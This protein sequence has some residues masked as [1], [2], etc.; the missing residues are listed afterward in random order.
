MKASY[1]ADEIAKALE[2]TKTPQVAE[3]LETIEGRCAMGVIAA[4]LCNLKGEATTDFYGNEIRYFGSGAHIDALP[5]ECV[6]ACGFVDR[7]GTF[8]E[9]LGVR[10]TKDGKRMRMKVGSIVEA[11]D[12]GVP[13]KTIAKLVRQNP[14]AVQWEA[15]PKPK[16]KRK[17]NAPEQ[18]AEMRRALK[19]ARE[20]DP[21]SV[22]IVKHGEVIDAETVQD[23]DP[24]LDAFVTGS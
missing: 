24:H 3:F 7:L 13:F 19:R 17:L 11:N 21:L 9:P 6:K 12:E 4:E 8:R 15:P 20:A 18:T 14:D 2:S 16:R 23:S 1:T 10:I 5:D 22:G